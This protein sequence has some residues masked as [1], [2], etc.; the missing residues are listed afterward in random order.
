MSTSM[1]DEIR[2]CTPVQHKQDK[3]E[4]QILDLSSKSQLN[5]N[6]KCKRKPIR[7]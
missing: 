4:K 7:K 1:P 5:H 2:I 6:P 3:E